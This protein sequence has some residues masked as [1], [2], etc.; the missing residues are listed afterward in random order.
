MTR[1]KR[2]K[3]ITPRSPGKALFEREV[4]AGTLRRVCGWIE[5]R[6][7]VDDLPDDDRLTSFRNELLGAA[8]RIERHQQ[9]NDAFLDALD[10]EED[11]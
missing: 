5:G 10:V 9:K 1:V 4:D 8:I 6:Q 2:Q 7:K 3:P 11:P